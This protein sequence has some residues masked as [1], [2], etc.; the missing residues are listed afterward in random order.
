MLIDV[1]FLSL[2]CYGLL[3]VDV[4]VEEISAKMKKMAS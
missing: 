4:D 2:R 3:Y 1:F